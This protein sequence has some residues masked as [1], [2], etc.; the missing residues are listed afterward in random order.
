MKLN[1]MTLEDLVCA[2]KAASTVRKYF[3]DK[4]AVLRESV[5]TPTIGPDDEHFEEIREMSRNLTMANSK[6]IQV[7]EEMNKRLLQMENE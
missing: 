6:R 2:E 7:I 1:K 4:I 5:G 3:E